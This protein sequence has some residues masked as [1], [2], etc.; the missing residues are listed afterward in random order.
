MVVE[1]VFYLY[2]LVDVDFVYVI[3]IDVF[4]SFYV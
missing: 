1:C 4:W 3:G 2:V